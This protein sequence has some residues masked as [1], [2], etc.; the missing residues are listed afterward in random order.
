MSNAS[1]FPIELNISWVP[2]FGGVPAPG[3]STIRLGDKDLKL[4]LSD[5]KA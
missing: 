3:Q 5:Q 1:T 4:R 2:M